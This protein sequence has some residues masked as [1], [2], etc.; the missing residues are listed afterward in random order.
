MFSGSIVALVTPFKNGKVDEKALSDLVSWHCTAGTQGVVAC[1]ST[2]E[3]AL[4][5]H[6]ER[7]CII[8]IVIEG[9]GNRIPVIVGCGAPSTHE[10][11]SMAVDAKRLKADAI[12]VVAPYY[13]KPTQDGL[14][15]HFKAIHDSV[16]LPLILYNNPGRCAID[17][18]IDLVLRLAELPNVIALKDSTND[19]SRPTLLRS[20]LTRKFSLLAG[21]D[22]ITPGYLAHGGNGC[23][24]VTA[25]VAPSLCQQ[26]IA[27]W[28]DVNIPEFTRL[29][30]VLMPLHQAMFIESN[31]TPVKYA[32]SAMGKIQ[33]EFKPP[34]LPVLPATGEKVSAVLKQ[35]G[36]V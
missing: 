27:A 2:G 22:G 23:I 33:N 13:V 28:Q 15:Q 36:L 12:L 29:T 4:L 34:L 8:S 5:T 18:S 24:S 6:D 25:N 30:Q 17:M 35:M 19:L 10:S 32:L 16:D 1:G 11:I 31:P 26:L 3:A 14:Y 21:D 20:R 9:A 7:N